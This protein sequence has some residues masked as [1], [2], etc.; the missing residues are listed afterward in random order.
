MR[1]S[2]DSRLSIPPDR[3]IRVLGS[4]NLRDLGGLTT[5]KGQL[6][7]SGCLYRS[8]FPAFAEADPDEF[9]RLRLAKVVDLRRRAEVEVEC[10]DWVGRGVGYRRWPLVAGREDSWH[11]GYTSYLTGKPETVVGAVREV[12]RPDGH[13]VLFHC[14]AG[15]DR[16]GVVAALL[17]AVLGVSRG[18][19]VEDYLLSAA[20]V[21][22]VITRLLSI[23][24]YAD[25]LSGSSVADQIPEPERIDRLLAWLDDHGGV[26]AWLVANGV[27]NAE[28]RSFRSALLEGVT[29]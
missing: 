12:M 1:V 14:A 28:I 6:V 24:V 19:I 4:H 29:E 3:S 26:E 15:K 13:A 18:D 17:L 21:E 25:M 8:D 23:E 27:S 16:T 5:V 7:R 10:V 9:A 2:L 20:S 11:A 22:S